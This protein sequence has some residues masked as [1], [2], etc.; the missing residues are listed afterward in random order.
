M[1]NKTIRPNCDILNVR[2]DFLLNKNIILELIMF[3]A[4]SHPFKL[5][6]NINLSKSNLTHMNPIF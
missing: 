3:S 4:L 6:Y 2:G 5:G 1:S